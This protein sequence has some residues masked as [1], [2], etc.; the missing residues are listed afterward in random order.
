MAR[1]AFIGQSFIEVNPGVQ[2]SVSQYGLIGA[3]PVVYLHGGPGAGCHAADVA[4]FDN[5]DLQVFFIDQ[6]HCGRSTKMANLASHT[7]IELIDDIDTV[8]RYF[9]VEQWAVTGGSYGA[10]LGWL[11]SGLYPDRVSEQVLWG[12]FLATPKARDWLYS[13]HG[14]ALFFADDYAEFIQP[15]YQ[16]C[17][18]FEQADVQSILSGYGQLL[19]SI[20][21]SI[22]AE[23][24]KAWNQW[25]LTLASPNQS[26]IFVLSSEL[27]DLAKIE[28]HHA[29][30]DYFNA[31]R[32]FETVTP[33]ITAK[34][35]LIQGEFDWICPQHLLMPFLANVT[36]SN[37]IF[38]EVKSGY[39]GL[40]DAKM[41]AR[42]MQKIQYMAQN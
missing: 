1:L 16:Y 5:L 18:W 2:L 41:Q 32:L 27:Y 4:L 38:D 9:G 31:V 22:C 24:V 3:K 20:D 12:L 6:R 8:R 28:H 23:S 19:S 39:H 15:L 30:H 29:E 35:T 26:R 33:S 11:Y 34:T 25:E 21:D 13:P 17:S 36:H 42:V 7:L 40:N 37:L 10:T 14:A